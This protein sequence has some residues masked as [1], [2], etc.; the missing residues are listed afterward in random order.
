MDSAMPELERLLAGPSPD[1]SAVLRWCVGAFRADLG[2]L[3]V[4]D[5]EARLLKLRADHRMPPA[6]REKVLEIPLGKGMAGMAAERREPVQVCNLQQDASGVVRP[7]AKASGMEG[8][9]AVPLLDALGAVRGV[10]GLANA[11]P[12]EWTADEQARCLEI[13]RRLAAAV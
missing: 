8:A 9:I 12:R 11:T 5:A 3:H 7:G 1:W 2:T 10:L 4:W 13:G 6:L